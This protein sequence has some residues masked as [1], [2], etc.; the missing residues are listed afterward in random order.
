MAGSPIVSSTRRT[1]DS[2][3][4]MRASGTALCMRSAGLASASSAAPERNAVAIGWRIDSA[5]TR[6][7]NGLGPATSV[8]ATARRF[9]R[10]PSQ[11]RRAGSST[12]APS[13]AAATASTP[14]TATLRSSGTG[15][16]V[17]TARLTATVSP[18]T[19]TARPAVSSVTTTAS[20]TVR[21]RASSSRKRWTR[22]SA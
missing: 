15:T 21:P 6:R 22:S 13:S 7:Q 16:H 10:G 12:S 20:A 17:I 1:S 18:E 11:A 3:P 5:P 4:N 8:R 9:T 14:P 19:Q 2:R